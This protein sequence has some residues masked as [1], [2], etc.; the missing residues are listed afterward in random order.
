MSDG[1]GAGPVYGGSV[2]S[3]ISAAVYCVLF[4]PALVVP[5]LIVSALVA[6]TA[7]AIAMALDG[8][9]ADDLVVRLVVV[10]LLAPVRPPARDLQTEWHL[11]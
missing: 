11:L 7:I 6:G 9:V 3:E 5:A 2:T 4:L 1:L 10:S 8:L